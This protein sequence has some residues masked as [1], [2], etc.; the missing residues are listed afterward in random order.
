MNGQNVGNFENFVVS[1]QV[2]ITQG[3]SSSGTQNDP[4]PFDVLITIGQP[5]TNPIAGSIQYAT[6]RYLYKF[7][8]DN[9]AI[10]LIDYAFVTSAGNSIGVTVD[11][12]I[13]AANQL[14][15]FNAGS[16]LTANVYIIT[17]G[18]FSITLS[19]TALSGSINVGGS[20]YILGGSA[21]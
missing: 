17:S 20:G 8:Y 4:N 12:R 3:I 11:T 9:N 15:N 21:S 6:N 2:L 13:A 18:G 7:I 16:G 14:S 19:G 10:S 1:G 5:A